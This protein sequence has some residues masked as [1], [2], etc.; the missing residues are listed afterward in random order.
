M[1]KLGFVLCI[2]VA[3]RGFR[4]DDL[5]ND[6]HEGE[7]ERDN[8]RCKANI[9]CKMIGCNSVAVLESGHW[10]KTIN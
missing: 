5:V 1:G 7:K 9:N 6:S 2:C 8:L 3:R 4:L 10:L